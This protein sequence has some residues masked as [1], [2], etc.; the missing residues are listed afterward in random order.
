MALATMTLEELLGPLNEFERK[1]APAMIFTSGDADFIRQNAR[2]AIVGSRKCSPEGVARARRLSKLLIEKNVVIVSGLAEGID[3]AA[4]RSAIDHGGR[5]VAVLGTPLERCFPASNTA[6][7]RELMEK[8]LVISQF[9]EGTNT[10]QWGF[11]V[12]NRLMALVSDATVIVEAGATSG[13]I[14]QGWEA[15]RLGRPLFLLESVASNTNLN[16]PEGMIGYG[17]RVLSDSNFD[18]LLIELPDRSQGSIASADLF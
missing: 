9:A 16:W 4:H 13:T 14:S 17:A 12:R 8:H 6:L 10:G 18:E 1:H 3:T 5:T 15:L 7:Q 11:P 2:V